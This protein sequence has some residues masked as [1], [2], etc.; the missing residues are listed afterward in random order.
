MSLSGAPLRRLVTGGRR[1]VLGILAVVGVVLLLGAAIFVLR[2]GDGAR[3]A[4][5]LDVLLTQL[6]EAVRA[7]PQDVGA[8]LS[9][10]AAYLE[11][12]LNE[13]AISQF[14][15]ALKLQE[16]N[17]TA[18]IGLG[19]AYLAEGDLR[20]AAEQFVRVIEMNKDNPYRYSIEQLQ[21]VHYDLGTIYLQAKQFE[22]AKTEFNEAL[23]INRADADT[24]RMLGKA[25]E[26]LGNLDGA[27]SAY[28][29]ATRLVPDYAD[30]YRDLESVY[31]RRAMKGGRLYAQGMLELVDG[32]FSDAVA[33]LEQSVATE[34]AGAEAFEGLGMAYE[35][36]GQLREA[37]ASYRRALELDPELMLS[38]L[39]VQRLET[40][41]V[42][43]QQGGGE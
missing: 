4:S 16:D 18:V 35:S 10:A 1:T 20:P 42:S 26:G 32:S 15:E 6:E 8:R 37:L 17:Q 22:H 14:E 28:K 2:G 38:S 29:M 33:L 36:N 24:W 43:G 13:N 9:V 21:G 25:E 12:G 30:V 39:G 23:K 41:G 27:I 7:N 19:Q 40:A 31:E 5:N 3:R 11:R 34:G